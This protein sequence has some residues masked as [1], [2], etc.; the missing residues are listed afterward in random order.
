MKRRSATAEGHS[1]DRLRIAQARFFSGVFRQ[2][3][4]FVGHSDATTLSLL[5]QV[6]GA[7]IRKSHQPAAYSRSIIVE[8]A[9]ILAA[10][11]APDPPTRAGIQLCFLRSLPFRSPKKLHT[12]RLG[13]TRCEGHPTPSTSTLPCRF[14]V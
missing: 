11:T 6:L 12:L 9:P 1:V 13:F 2:H 3:Q 7:K 5:W 4:M 14:A 8:A 10:R